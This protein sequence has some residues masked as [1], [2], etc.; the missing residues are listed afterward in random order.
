MSTSEVTAFI[1]KE[2]EVWRPIAHEVS[3]TIRK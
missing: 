1:Q 3:A 2:Q